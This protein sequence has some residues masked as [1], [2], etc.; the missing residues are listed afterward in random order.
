MNDARMDAEL[1]KL[2]FERYSGNP[3]FAAQ[4]YLRQKYP[5]DFDEFVAFRQEHKGTPGTNVH[6]RAMEDLKEY[7]DGVYTSV[8]ETFVDMLLQR[9][10]GR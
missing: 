10:V 4:E 6:M 3:R 9:R 7:H 2:I 1:I 5:D 8:Y